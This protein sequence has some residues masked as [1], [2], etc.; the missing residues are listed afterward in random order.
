M[1]NSKR[2]VFS[3]LLTGAFLINALFWKEQMG[4]NTLLFDL[5]LSAV[6]FYLYPEARRS[7]TVRWLF[8]GRLTTL[9]MVLWHHTALS[10]TAYIVLT[11]FSAVFVQYAHRSVWYAMGSFALNGLFVVPGIINAIPL[12]EKSNARKVRIGRILRLLIIPGIIAIPFLV[13]YSGSN[14]IFS[15]YVERFLQWGADSFGR[16]WELFSP[17]RFFFLLVGLLITGI[18]ILRPRVNFFGE[19]DLRHSDQLHRLRRSVYQS[20]SASEQLHALFFGSWAKG[21]LALKYWY[22]V[23]LV[24]LALLNLMLMTLN[25]ID[26]SVLWFRRVV[27]SPAQLSQMTHEGI[28]FLILSLILAIAVLLIFFR[29]NLNFYKQSKGLR[30]LVLLWIIQNGILIVSV[31]LRDYYYISEAGLTYKRIGVVVYLLLALTGLVTVFWK[32]TY[33][34]SVYFLFRVNAWAAV[35]ILVVSST[36]NWDA[37]I[38]QWYINRSAQK[39]VPAQYLYALSEKTWPLLEPHLKVHPDSSL[40]AYGYDRVTVQEGIR[41]RSQEYMARQKQYSFLSWNWQDQK[42]QRYLTTLN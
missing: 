30:L 17:G 14:P 24:S 20:R 37:Y 9:A 23:G 3:L 5:F 10:Q 15:G 21:N 16:F 8:L 42:I 36:V 25:S 34:R 12:R 19:K 39:P 41:L 18:L 11:I 4:L 40:V 33:N 38:T 6:L 2:V 28:D 35:V 22:W 27:A 29:G 32:I 13:L 7:S 26:I 1:K 31:A